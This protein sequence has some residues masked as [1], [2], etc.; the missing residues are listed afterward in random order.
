MNQQEKDKPMVN[1]RRE[2][3]EEMLNCAAERG[4]RRALHDVGLDGDDAA[5]DIRDLRS[6]LK[7]IHVAKHTAWQ[8]VIRIT[9]TG[10]IIALM[11]GAVIKLKLFGG[12]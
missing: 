5:E 9:T 8:T 1:L 10:L 3:F 6:L 7:A 2:E 4:A 11:A 12:H